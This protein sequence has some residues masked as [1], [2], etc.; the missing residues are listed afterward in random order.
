MGVLRNLKNAMENKFEQPLEFPPDLFKKFDIVILAES[1]HGE[2]DDKIIKFLEQFINQID[3]IFI[4]L[5]INYQQFVDRY[6]TTGEVDQ[7]LEDLFVGAE[8]EGKN[9]RGLLAILD[10]IK[11]MQKSATCFDSSKI[12]QGEYQNPS[13]YGRYFLRGKSRDDDMFTVLQEYQQQNPGKYLLINGANHSALGQHPQ[14]GD[15]TLGQKLHDA[16]DEK[17]TEIV[18]E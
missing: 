11:A 13:N 10:K 3:G 12:P 4:E 7:S 1:R 5:P 16:Y 8:K 9:T 17:F 18:M 6:M 2:H 14:S 15:V